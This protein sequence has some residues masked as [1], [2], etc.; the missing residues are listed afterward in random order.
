MSHVQLPAKLT[1]FC[2]ISFSCV[3]SFAYLWRIIIRIQGMRGMRSFARCSYM[4]KETRTGTRDSNKRQMKSDEANSTASNE[5]NRQSYRR[6]YW[7]FAKETAVCV[8]VEARN[9]ETQFP[10]LA[11]SPFSCSRLRTVRIDCRYCG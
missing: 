8:I 5:L 1:L 3:P 2:C 7:R 6:H 10:F 9:D 4:E 11:S